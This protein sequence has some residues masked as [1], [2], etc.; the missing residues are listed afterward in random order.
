MCDEVRRMGEGEMG[1][2]NGMMG[3]DG[4]VG[5]VRVSASGAAAAEDMPRARARRMGVM[6]EICIFGV[7][8]YVCTSWT[9]VRAD[10]CR[11]EPLAEI[12]FELIDDG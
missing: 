5:H 7:C 9:F 4:M 2:V 11:L 10:S 8:M 12:V 3:S 6:S 1:N